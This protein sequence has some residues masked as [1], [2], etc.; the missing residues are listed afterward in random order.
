MLIG[1]ETE[2]RNERALWYGVLYGFQFHSTM[3]KLREDQPKTFMGY[4]WPVVE[5]LTNKALSAYRQLCRIQ[6]I[7]N[8]VVNH[9]DVTIYDLLKGLREEH[10]ALFAIALKSSRTGKR[11]IKV[12]NRD[13]AAAYD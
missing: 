12:S 5:V 1:D 3:M 9:Y 8:D 4:R 2:K 6:N 13:V 7:R 11:G 10:N